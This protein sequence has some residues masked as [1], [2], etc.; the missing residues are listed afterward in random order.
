MFLRV[1]ARDMK[2]KFTKWKWDSMTLA[3]KNDVEWQDGNF[4]RMWGHRY[5]AQ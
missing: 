2:R 3:W 4:S 1:S 5:K